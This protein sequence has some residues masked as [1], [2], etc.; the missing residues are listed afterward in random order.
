MT[1][2]HKMHNFKLKIYPKLYKLKSYKCLL[3][4]FQV[5]G[6]LFAMKKIL[7]TTPLISLYC[8][9]KLLILEYLGK[10]MRN[11]NGILT[12]STRLSLETTVSVELY[13]R[14]FVI[15]ENT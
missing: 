2:Q 15:T 7:S 6:I 12:A 4:Y 14:V 8:A 3:M 11:F 9:F 1:R 5:I 13:S 10:S